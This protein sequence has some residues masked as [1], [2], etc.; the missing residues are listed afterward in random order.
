[1]IVSN[2][3]A[4]RTAEPVGVQRTADERIPASAWFGLAVMII[5]SIYA[6][7]DRQI[8]ILFAEAIRRDMG[9]SDTQ[10]G[11]L[12]GLGLSLIGLL[13]V[14]PISALA[15]RYDRRWVIAICVLL[16]SVAVAGCGL[17][18]S[19]VPLLTFAALVGVGEA[20]TG[21]AALAM[22]PDLFPASARQLANSIFV[23]ASRLSQSIGV[24]LA[25]MLIVLVE[26]VRP[27][28]P[29]AIARMPEWRLC[30]FAAIAFS[31]VAVAL[32]LMLPR[33]T[34]GLR[35]AAKRPGSLGAAAPAPQF[36]R[37]V[38]AHRGPFAGV[39]GATLCNQ[40][41][42]IATA[43]WIPIIAQRYFGQT[44][45]Q[46]GEWLASMALVTAGLGFAIGTA[47][48]PW[49]RARSQRWSDVL[50]LAWVMFLAALTSAFIAFAQSVAQLY[51]LWGLQAIVLTV[52]TMILPTML[53]NMTPVPMRA[54]VF[55]LYIFSQISAA[56]GYVVV[57][58]LSDALRGVERG[59][60]YAAVSVAIVF[61]VLSGIIFWRTSRGY[62]ALVEEVREAELGSGS[63]LAEPNGAQG[64]A[65][66]G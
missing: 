60:L 22:L 8:F 53:Q 30:F 46:S 9:L 47:L 44:P 64:S 33:R 2:A 17:A 3:A 19:F 40:F 48:L 7:V 12:Q 29:L 43:G 66:A 27:S 62:V 63:S 10:L 23:I 14:Y 58:A 38:A 51:I 41:G 13:T 50:A 24:W 25:G 4:D 42:L 59:L 61:L 34:A 1:M 15:D 57:G 45:Q 54:R 5:V 20:G 18:P 37:Y 21:P 55:A 35:L 16:W 52:G 6:I 26:W 32:I 65:I 28:L 49:F 39:V 36:W 31:P 56:L 11:M